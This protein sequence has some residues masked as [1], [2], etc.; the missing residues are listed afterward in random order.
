MLIGYLYMYVTHVTPDNLC[1]T[2]QT[3]F[4]KLNNTNM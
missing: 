3:N 2:D 1:N 4:I